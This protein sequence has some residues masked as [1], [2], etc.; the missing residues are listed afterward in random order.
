M[1]DLALSYAE[2]VDTFVTIHSISDEGV[3]AFKARLRKLQGEGVPEGANPGKGKR[4]SYNLPMLCEISVALELM[5]TGYSA[6]AISR[7]LAGQT[8][9]V[10]YVMLAADSWEDFTDP[11]I[12]LSPEALDTLTSQK[13]QHDLPIRSRARLLYRIS[14]RISPR[15]GAGKIRSPYDA[16]YRRW[17]LIDL[18]MLAMALKAGLAAATNAELD[19]VERTFQAAAELHSNEVRQIQTMLRA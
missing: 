14:K 18:R 5:Q 3:D 8:D 13:G 19:T 16:E 7:L 12:F 6:P 9:L 2:M 10:F 1:A 4:V 11:M 17:L 15:T